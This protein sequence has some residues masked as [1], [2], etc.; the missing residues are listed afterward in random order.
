M[1][2]SRISSVVTPKTPDGEVAARRA[3]TE[4]HEFAFKP[5]RPFDFGPGDRLAGA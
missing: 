4:A 3:A 5:L 2:L 1:N